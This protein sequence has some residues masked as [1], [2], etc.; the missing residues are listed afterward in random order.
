M[1]TNLFLQSVSAWKAYKGSENDKTD[2]HRIILVYKIDENSFYY[3]TVTSQIEKAKNRSKKDISSLV[4]LDKSEWIALTKSSCIECGK[5]NLKV[6]SRSEL[7][8]LYENNKL[9]VLPELPKTI[10]DKIKRAICFSV[11]YTDSEKKLYTR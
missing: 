11:T 9:Q 8:E 6:I 3:F 5:R 2:G 10:Q 4:E 7:K 1:P